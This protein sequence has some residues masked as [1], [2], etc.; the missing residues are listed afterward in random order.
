MVI[1]FEINRKMS[2]LETNQITKWFN[3]ASMGSLT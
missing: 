3:I 2:V 1:L